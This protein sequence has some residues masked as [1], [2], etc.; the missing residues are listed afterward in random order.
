MDG[1][2]VIEIKKSVFADNDRDAEALRAELKARGD[3]A[4][5]ML[6]DV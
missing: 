6:A 1:V 4:A 3:R 2:K 5:K